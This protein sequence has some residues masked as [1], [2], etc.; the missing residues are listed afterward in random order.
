MSFHQQTIHSHQPAC[1]HFLLPNKDFILKRRFHQTEKK[2]HWQPL[3]NGKKWFSLARK[4]V[5]D[6]QEQSSFLDCLLLIPIMVPTGGKIALT[7]KILFPL[8][9]KFICTSRMKD[10][11]KY[12]STYRKS[13]SFQ[14]IF[15]KIGK[16]GPHLKVAFH[17][18]H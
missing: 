4:S 15:K 13:A 7:K 12:A 3:K 6:K 8:T 5:V 17:L 1:F 14:K 11:E 10:I 18:F 2:N 9:R 16:K